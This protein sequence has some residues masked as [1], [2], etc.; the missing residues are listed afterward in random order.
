MNEFTPRLLPAADAHRLVLHNIKTVGGLKIS[1][2]Q[3]LGLVMRVEIFAS[4]VWRMK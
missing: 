3:G 4:W 1:P 2:G